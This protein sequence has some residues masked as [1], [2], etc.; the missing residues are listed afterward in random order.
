MD[1]ITYSKMSSMENHLRAIARSSREMAAVDA[2]ILKVGASVDKLSE[3][4]LTLNENVVTGFEG[5]AHGLK[6]VAKRI[7]SG[8]LAIDL[9]QQECLQ[10]LKK[11]NLISETT[12][13][14]LIAGFNQ[15]IKR[16]DSITTSIAD[17]DDKISNPERT[18]A[19]EAAKIA[20]EYAKLGRVKDALAI[21][22]KAILNEGGIPQHHVPQLRIM[23]GT[24]LLGLFD[25]LTDKVADL[26]RAVVEF[27]EAYDFGSTVKPYV[28][29][30]IAEYAGIAHF[31]KE[32]YHLAL[33][34]FKAPDIRG[35]PEGQF[36]TLRCHIKLGEIETATDIAFNILERDYQAI[37]AMSADPVCNERADIALAA[38]NKIR[39]SRVGALYGLL[40][41]VYA[42]GIGIDEILEKTKSHEGAIDGWIQ[43]VS[44][45][46]SFVNNYFTKEDEDFLK[47]GEVPQGW[48]PML[49]YLYEEMKKEFAENDMIQKTSHFYY[50]EFEG[51]KETQAKMKKAFPPSSIDSKYIEVFPK[52]AAELLTIFLGNLMDSK[53]HV[54]NNMRHDPEQHQNPDATVKALIRSYYDRRLAINFAKEY[55]NAISE[56]FYGAKISMLTYNP[57]DLKPALKVSTSFGAGDSEKFKLMAEKLVEA[58][59]PTTLQRMF[60]KAEPFGM[61]STQAWY[62]VQPHRDK[63]QAKIAAIHRTMR[64]TVQQMIAN[65]YSKCDAKALKDAY[66]QIQ[67]KE[68]Q[69][70]Q[71]GKMIQNAIDTAKPFLT[72]DYSYFKP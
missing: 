17:I 36:Q 55:L 16:L 8:F 53:T 33:N 65:L 49:P 63:A 57:C 19:L 64:D 60:K 43:A 18:K 24:L 20:A 42:N 25:G 4:V 50:P 39:T 12:N 7:N 40:D 30:Q 48:M 6:G 61:K 41:A 68:R 69:H 23:K 27:K 51:S 22:D 35:F 14:N 47:D 1:M 28:R 15:V 59:Q 52:N 26:D 44:M 58:G 11:L 34:W 13:N 46:R 31:A 29:R 71:L 62:I 37:V 45:K 10:E 72:D 56:I 54:A 9:T 3:N 21:V 5:V 38:T 32:E 70:S 2:S 66:L 67:E